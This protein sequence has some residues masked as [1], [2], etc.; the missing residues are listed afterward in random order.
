MTKANLRDNLGT[1][2]KA[3][4]ACS[5]TADFMKK[6]ERNSTSSDLIG[7]FG[8]GF[9][10]VFLVA[11]SVTV[12]SKHNSDAQY[13]WESS[14]ENG[15]TLGRG[16]QIIIHLKPDSL[17]FTDDER[18]RKLVRKHSQF[19][20]FPIYLW[21]I[22]TIEEE[23]EEPV[24]EPKPE[25]DSDETVEDVTDADTT[26][27][28]PKTKT[29][30]RRIADWELLNQHKPIWTRPP[31]SVTEEEYGEFYKSFFRDTLPALAHSHFKAEG[32]TEFRAIIFVPPNPPYKF[33]QPDEPQGKNVR[34]F[35]RRVFI[36]DELSN[37]LP[38]WLSFIRVVVD[39]DDLPLNVSRETLQK[40]SLLKL[41]RKKLIG[42]TL[43]ML[44]KLA[45]N[46]ELYRKF[47]K[48]YRMAI[49]FG[50][51]ETKSAHKKLVRL[52]RY[53]STTHDFTSL[54][55][56]VGR[57]KKNQPQIYYIS[58]P[59]A[60]T[61]RNSPVVETLV[62][63]G[64]EVLFLV[65]PADEHLVQGD[66]KTF[67][68]KPMQHV[69][70]TGLKFGDE[71]EKTAA[72]ETEL[73]TKFR[74]LTDWLREKLS[75]WVDKVRVSMQLTT[76]PAA[77]LSGEHGLSP[78]QER[79]YSA[80]LGDRDDPMF[81][82]YMGLKRVFEINP[83]HPIIEGLLAK[84][85]DGR[86]QEIES[87]PYLLFEST[88]IAS[89]WEPRDR[90]K[91]MFSVESALRLIVGVDLDKKPDIKVEPAPEAEASD[92]EAAAKEAAAAKE[93]AS[94]DD[95]EYAPDPYMLLHEEL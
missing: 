11:E 57:M 56:Y 68:G 3:R 37:F 20:N 31:S 36:T 59:D 53:E 83:A 50:L 39:S 28:E 6:L 64:Y 27:A 21:S 2:A 51:V 60:E 4:A 55:D 40:N 29:V 42:K 18:L 65:D 79:L 76:S 13:I 85:N 25:S 47:Y 95:D 89:G 93:S 78:S 10:S 34:L 35:V 87:I 81:N 16:T 63:R 62:A 12:I 30:E 84:I 48:S 94:T 77:V 38:R 19:I 24:E 75:T 22:R 23:V 58:A 74:P 17:E 61:A 82:Y 14:S 67:M 69:G 73:A 5:G 7:Q 92:K 8:V 71:D 72:R 45:E 80:Q 15:N 86:E 91:F 70:R 9:Y 32:D 90:K 43:D 49:K 66:L 26:T 88:A 54:E 46:D 41:I 44:S 1:I 33:L 52:L